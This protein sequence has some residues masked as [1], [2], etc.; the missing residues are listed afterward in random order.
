MSDFEITCIT[1]D[2]PDSDRR[3][4]AVGFAG[5]VY[6]IDQVIGYIQRG[7]HRSWV[8]SRPESV[9]VGVRQHPTSRRYFLATEPDGQPL[10]N[11]ASLSEC[12]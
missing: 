7:E 12:P 8:R 5:S 11:L 10:N 4:D 9:W 2:G 3:I 1:R 6:P